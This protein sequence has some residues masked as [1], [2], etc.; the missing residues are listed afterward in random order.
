MLKFGVNWTPAKAA[1]LSKS[2][3]YIAKHQMIKLQIN[4][5]R[6]RNIDVFF[7]KLKSLFWCK[8][9][10]APIVNFIRIWSNWREYLFVSKNV[11]SNQFT[12]PKFDVLIQLNLSNEFQLDKLY[13]SILCQVYKSNFNNLHNKSFNLNLETATNPINLKTNTNVLCCWSNVLQIR[14]NPHV[15]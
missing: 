4:F 2:D 12:L 5:N 10:I 15:Y 9:Q 14:T 13:H 1:G 6:R 8:I 7:F 3:K 11:W